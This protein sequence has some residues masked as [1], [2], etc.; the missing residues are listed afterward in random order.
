[1]ATCAALSLRENEE[2]LHLYNVAIFSTCAN[3]FR[4]TDNKTRLTMNEFE[5]A[6]ERVPV[7]IVSEVYV[8]LRYVNEDHWKCVRRR[9]PI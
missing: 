9:S 5:S 3:Y 1:M 8:V 6:G 2:G 4:T 7:V